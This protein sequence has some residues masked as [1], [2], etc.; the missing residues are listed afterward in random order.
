[1]IITVELYFM[2]MLLVYIMVEASGTVTPP[3]EGR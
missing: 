1:M 3:A 2:A